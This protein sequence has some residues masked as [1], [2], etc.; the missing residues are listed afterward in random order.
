MTDSATIAN[1]IE[2]TDATPEIEE[3]FYLTAEFWVSVTFI[4]VAV[5]L[6]SPL[7]KKAKDLVQKRIDRIK[8]ELNLP[9]LL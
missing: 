4:I 5:I 7:V 1:L 3:V 9:H 6:Y 2:N 8:K